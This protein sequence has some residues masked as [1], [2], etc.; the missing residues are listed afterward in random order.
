MDGYLNGWGMPPPERGAPCKGVLNDAFW[1]SG[2]GFFGQWP[3]F[4]VRRR[5]YAEIVDIMQTAASY[6][7]RGRWR[8]LL[9][10]ERT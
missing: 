2:V 8:P 4:L 7:T 1:R 9:L 10:P 6:A 3:E 5:H